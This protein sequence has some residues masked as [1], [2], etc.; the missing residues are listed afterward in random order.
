MRGTP[1]HPGDNGPSGLPGAPGAGGTPGAPGIPGA[2]GPMPDVSRAWNCIMKV[3]LKGEL[4]GW[5]GVLRGGLFLFINSNEYVQ[6]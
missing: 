2:P 6:H 4:G 1:G 3:G 5:G